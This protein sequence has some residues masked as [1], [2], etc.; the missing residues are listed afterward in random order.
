MKTSNKN[1]DPKMSICVPVYNVEKYIERCTRSIL[2]QTLNEI[3]I[4]FINDCSPDNSWEILK[5][6]IEEYPQRKDKIKLLENDTNSGPGISRQNCA[7]IANGEYIYFADSDDWLEPNMLERLYEL[8]I[9][10]D[11]DI[12]GCQVNIVTKT[13]SRHVSNYRTNFSHEEWISNM[14]R[15]PDLTISIALW[16]RL[17]RRKIYDSTI[18]ED[19]LIKDLVRF[20]DFL[21]VI[22]CHYF[23]K[24]VIWIN[25]PLYNHDWSNSKSVT[26]KTDVRAIESYIRQGDALEKFFISQND[27]RFKA[28]IDQ[29]KLKAKNQL[30]TNAKF[31]SPSRWRSLWP[32]LNTKYDVSKKQSLM[33][34]LANL[35]L[36][37]ILTLCAN[38]YSKIR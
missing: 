22:K 6:V 28:E 12:V 29:F 8:A 21:N 1:I 4:I 34:R 10:S 38:L 35:K 37:F 24:K 3:E 36:D 32:E 27:S 19:Y 11:A 23:S 30:I 26:K 25:E 17:I 33:M 7:R 20:E 14:I 2:E 31:L 16:T 5:S 15:M 18:V 9:E 13:G